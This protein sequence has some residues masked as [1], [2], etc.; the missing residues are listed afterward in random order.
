MRIYNNFARSS[1]I[2]AFK[3]GEDCIK[4]LCKCGTLYI[5]TEASVGID[6]IKIM[7][8]LAEQGAGLDDYILQNVKGKHARKL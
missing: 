8:S 3:I 5:Y 4:V 2:I 6:A 7:K 1:Q